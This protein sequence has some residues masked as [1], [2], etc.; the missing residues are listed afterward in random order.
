MLYR[1]LLGDSWSS[2]ADAVRRLHDSAAPVHAAGAFR[3]RHGR[4]LFARFI[5]TVALLPAPSERAE[6]QLRISPLR[7]GEEWRRTFAG[8]PL[9]TVQSARNGGLVERRGC[10]ELF[11]RLEAVRGA[12]IY[13]T[14]GAALA[15]GASHVPLPGW[16]SPQVCAVE[17][18]GMGHGIDVYVEVRLPLI[19]LLI[20]YEGTLNF[21]EASR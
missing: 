13:R 11:F 17:R 2:L 3:V 8:Q 21:V 15:L 1:S 16:L 9:V 10:I 5:A 14:T 4:N 20:A 12:L 18:A 6:V 19:G 7:T